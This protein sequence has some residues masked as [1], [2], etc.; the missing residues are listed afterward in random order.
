[1][2]EFPCADDNKRGNIPFTRQNERC[3]FSK[4]NFLTLASLRSYPNQQL[5]KI[6]V[7][8][9]DNS[10]DFE[11]SWTQEVI[12]QSLFQVGEISR[13]SSTSP[14]SFIWKT[15]IFQEKDFDSFL[16]LLEKLGDSLLNAPSKHREF[17][18]LAE[19]VSYFGQFSDVIEARRIIRKYFDMGKSW[20]DNEKILRKSSEDPK[21]IHQHL[22][23]ETFMIGY[24][25]LA[26]GILAIDSD[27]EAVGFLESLVRFRN[28]FLLVRQD[29]SIT[30]QLEKIS[31]K[32]IEASSRNL[33]Q[34]MKFVEADRLKVLSSAFLC[35]KSNL[36]QNL[37]WTR[38]KESSCYTSWHGLDNYSIN[39]FDGVV[40]I[41]GN[42]PSTLPASIRSHDLFFRIF[43]DVDFQ[44]A[45]KI[46][47]NSNDTFFESVESLSGCFYQFALVENRL[48]II[49]V[50]ED[51]LELMDHSIYG[52]L[53]DSL[54]VR[55]CSMYSHWYSHADNI[56]FYRPHSYK[57]KSIS[58][59][60]QATSTGIDSFCYK[61]PQSLKSM[62]RTIL[63]ERMHEFDRI[64]RLPNSTVL[65]VLSLFEISSCIELYLTS[66]GQKLYSLPRFNLE[67]LLIRDNESVRLKSLQHNN[68]HLNPNQRLEKDL[69]GHLLTFQSYLLLSK[70]TPDVSL[71]QSRILIPIG[72]IIKNENKNIK[73]YLPESN[74][75]S[76]GLYCYDVHPRLNCIISDSIPARLKLAAIYATQGILPM[77]VFIMSGLQYS[78]HL[79][80]QCSVNRP[81]T[82][83]EMN[84]AKEI[85]E[86]SSNLPALKILVNYVLQCQKT[87]FYV[88]M[89]LG[90]S[91]KIRL[92]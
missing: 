58:F 21:E 70:T 90:F 62:S 68:Y 18:I 65:P 60:L 48:S 78:L 12:R 82:P 91:L 57:Q 7:A 5:R 52:D 11:S 32:V 14:L 71:L 75:S 3:N 64:I 38:M 63:K 69:R 27:I 9:I 87:L 25:I 51:Q 30:K 20:A 86:H 83:D 80:R 67:F 16:V 35:V 72:K 56:L 6:A 40:L 77:L 50:G 55:L 34:L 41:N 29:N 49:E 36:P 61:I 88:Q 24:S 2:I 15:D 74:K 42:P 66:A 89:I 84:S 22:I 26:Y 53:N 47:E 44:V 13:L 28:C 81:L 59:I 39:V 17:L 43:G 37:P 33:K 54:P 92:R 79:L 31:M 19:M 85:D 4:E 8:M 46:R 45:A 23:Q 76:I 1:M 73:I 10:L